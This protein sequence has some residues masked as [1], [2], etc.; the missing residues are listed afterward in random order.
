MSDRK[1]GFRHFDRILF[2]LALFVALDFLRHLKEIKDH[3]VFI[4]Q[5]SQQDQAI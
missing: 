5:D 3:E 4:D 2:I 1:T